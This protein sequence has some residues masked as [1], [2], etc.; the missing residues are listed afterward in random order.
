MLMLDGQPVAEASLELL[1]SHPVLAAANAAFLDQPQL[2]LP[3]RTRGLCVLQ[4]EEACVPRTGGK[5]IGSEDATTCVIAV[6]LGDTHAWAGHF[7][8]GSCGSVSTVERAMARVGTPSALF[9]AG[10]CSEPSGVGLKVALSLVEL[11]QLSSG[12]V[13]LRLC[14]VAA[15]NTS[16]AGAPRSRQLVID[17]STGAPHPYT[18]RD[19]GP[20][21]PRRMAASWCLPRSQSLRDLMD[22]SGSCVVLPLVHTRLPGGRLEYCAW[23]LAKGDQDLLQSYSTSPEQEGPKFLPGR[24]WGPALQLVVYLPQTLG[25]RR[26]RG[27]VDGACVPSAPAAG[28]RPPARRAHAAVLSS[29]S[30]LLPI[31]SGG[32][33][34]RRR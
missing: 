16:P 10:S 26:M 3:P 19:R 12:Q 18:F 23:L 20:N 29:S 33:S 24:G 15:A 6:L 27:R 13:E 31:S 25:A 22:P 21:V 17:L 32:S 5:F 4:G 30:Q 7:D 11:F 9:L 2:E 14:C 28:S 8:E 1:L 34:S